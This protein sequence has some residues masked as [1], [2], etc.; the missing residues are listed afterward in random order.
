MTPIDGE[1]GDAPDDE[2][3]RTAPRRATITTRHDDPSVVAGALE[4][5]NTDQMTTTV[6]T[7][8]VVT[9]IDRPGTG[10][11]QSTVDD[12][13]VNLQVAD[14]VAGDAATRDDRSGGTSDDETTHSQTNDATDTPT[15]DT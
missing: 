4:P 13:L 1:N 11:L 2:A 5:D 12:Y 8:G 10:G 6:T 14:S 3:S 7:E 9:T 15:N